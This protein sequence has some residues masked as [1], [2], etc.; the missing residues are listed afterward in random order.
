MPIF[1]VD[2]TA[3]PLYFE[4]LHSGMLLKSLFRSFVLVSNPINVHSDYEDV[5]VEVDFPEHESKLQISCDDF[6]REPSDSGTV[7]PDVEINESSSLHSSVRGTS[8]AGRNGLYRNII[9]SRS[10]QK[11]RSS[12]RKRKTRYSLAVSLKR[13][14]GALA[15]DLLGGM[16]S[17][18][19]RRS[20]RNVST[21]VNLRHA[22]SARL[23]S[24]EEQ[25]SS[26]LCSANI[27]I[28]ES[29]Q[30]YR[31]EGAIITLEMS[32]SSR[33]WI[34]VVKKDGLT[35]CSFKAEKVMQPCSSNRLTHVIAFPLDNRWKLEFVNRKDWAVFKHL[36]KECS[37]RNIAA[38]V[39]KCIPVPGV[40]EVSSYAEE[41]SVLF[42]RPDT[43][44]SVYGDEL[45]RA[46]TRRTANYDM[47]SEDGEWLSSKFNNEFQEHVSEDN[48]ELII[49]ALEK[50]YYCNPD[51]CFDKQTAVNACLGYGSKEVVE[52]VYTYWMGKRKQQR[53]SLLVKVFQVNSPLSFTY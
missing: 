8:V 22:S 51:D 41:N 47:D 10:I 13:C 5:E 17:N 3:V 44:I 15:S 14:N 33:E 37:D 6:K 34:L 35:R 38:P 27:L 29:D 4:Y 39:S 32:A 49:D 42:H 19:K 53:R 12:L 30:C 36:Y 20:L 24:A 43:Y 26:S 45:T 9:H 52:A 40:R 25:G 48:F 18:S 1:C 50:V 2:F 28:M 16:E 11:R 23:D 21:A 7:T 31:V 46:M